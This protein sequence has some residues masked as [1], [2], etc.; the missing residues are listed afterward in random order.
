MNRYRF[1]DV[2]VTCLEG[3]S[4]SKPGL[5][6]SL[7]KTRFYAV[8][9]VTTPATLLAA[10]TQETPLASPLGDETHAWKNSP[11]LRFNSEASKFHDSCSMLVIQLRMRRPFRRDKDVGEALVVPVF[12]LFECAETNRA[13]LSNA[14]VYG[15]ASVD[16][17]RVLGK[18]KQQGY[19]YFSYKFSNIYGREVG[20][21]VVGG[22]GGGGREKGV[23]V[24]AAAAAWRSDSKR[25][26]KDTNQHRYSLEE[27]NE[28][29]YQ[30]LLFKG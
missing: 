21:K 4:G 27:I 19:L 17:D 30:L 12:E 1:L 14:A 2:D 25:K 10:R 24:V 3:L 8:V 22:G 26:Y 18:K 13:S 29:A 9:S 23:S 15:V 7:F 20:I 11:P 6:N 16:N 28:A 5:I